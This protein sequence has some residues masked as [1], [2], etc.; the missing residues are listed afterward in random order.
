[1][2]FKL[3]FQPVIYFDLKLTSAS[4]SI[5]PTMATTRLKLTL[6]TLPAEI[7][8]LI[9]KLALPEPDATHVFCSLPHTHPRHRRPDEATEDDLKAEQ[10]EMCSF[11]HPKPDI[12]LLLTCRQVR[13][14]TARFLVDG[15]L[16]SGQ[17]MTAVFSS[18]A[19]F[20]DVSEQM[21]PNQRSRIKKIIIHIS[22]WDTKKLEEGH[23]TLMLDG[24]ID[25]VDWVEP[26]L[27][28]DFGMKAI[29]VRECGNG[30]GKVDVLEIERVPKMTPKRVVVGWD[31]FKRVSI[32]QLRPESALDYSSDGH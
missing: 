31:P 13:D 21:T 26:Q 23:A 9:F 15:K 12:S 30:P 28:I 8:T 10:S 22:D 7:R 3:S 27:A 29:R 32:I 20:Q 14:E 24:L 25:F 18:V 4:S 16:S 1:M 11:V 5:P 17:N 2:N 19:C 6:L